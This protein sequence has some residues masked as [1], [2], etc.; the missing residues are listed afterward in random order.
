MLKGLRKKDF[1]IIILFYF[2]ALIQSSFLSHFAIRGV[3]PNL[4]LITVLLFCLFESPE[5][6]LGKSSGFSGGFFLDVF[7]ASPLGTATFSLFFTAFIS[8]KVLQDLKK[9]DFPF[10]F[11]FFV[12]AVLL[13]ELLALF[14]SFVFGIALEGLT[15]LRVPLDY[16]IPIALIYNSLLGLGGFFLLRKRKNVH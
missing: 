16:S 7:S 2:L 13:F 6:S 1:L 11:L 15:P 4:I 12:L 8:K 3:S 10:V 9:I 14:F 5:G